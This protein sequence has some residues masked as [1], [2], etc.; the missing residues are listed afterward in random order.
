[1]TVAVDS[2]RRANEKIITESLAR[3][4]QLEKAAKKKSPKRFGN[5]LKE[6][7]KDVGF[8][9]LGYLLGRGSG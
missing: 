7:G 5:I 2:E 8:F 1:L 6:I 3:I 9:G 4:D